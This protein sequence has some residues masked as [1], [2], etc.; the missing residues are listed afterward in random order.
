MPWQALAKEPAVLAV[1]VLE[2]N[3]CPMIVGL[4]EAAEDLS[5]QWFNALVSHA[6]S[7]D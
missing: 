3:G 1:L 5:Q 6:D 2:V 7:S 4:G